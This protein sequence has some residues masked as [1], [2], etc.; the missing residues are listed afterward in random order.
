MQEPSAHQRPPPHAGPHSLIP[1]HLANR[2]P[3]YFVLGGLVFTVITE[4]YLGSEYG[5]HYHT[6]AP[7][8]LLDLLWH[9]VPKTR[10][11]QAVV[12]SQVLACDTTVGYEDVYN[13]RVRPHRLAACA[14]KTET[15]KHLAPTRAGAASCCTMRVQGVRCSQTCQDGA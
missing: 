13:E 6:M 7:V 15:C 10:A 5:E 3:S 4:P 1:P 9:G 12:V 2:D 8:A 11:E 14:I